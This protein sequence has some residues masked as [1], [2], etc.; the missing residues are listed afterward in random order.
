[1]F[2]EISSCANIKSK[3][4]R[5]SV[6]SAL[7]QIQHYFKN[8]KIPENGIALFSGNQNLTI[9]VPPTPITHFLY[10]CDKLFHT[11]GLMPLYEIH[12]HNGIVLV[13]GSCCYIY[14]VTNIKTTLLYKTSVSLQSRQKKGGQS[15]VRIARLA[16]ERRFLFVKQIAENINKQY[17]T[18]NSV[19]VKSIVIAGP[20]EMK[21]AVVNSELLDYRL[22][23]LVTKITIDTITDDTLAK[24]I[25][26]NLFDKQQVSEDELLAKQIITSIEL[27]ENKYVYGLEEIQR[28]I[29]CHNV[30][31]L[32]TADSYVCQYFDVDI[33]IL[34]SDLLLAY[35]GVILQPYYTMDFEDQD[36]LAAAAEDEDI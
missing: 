34:K 28:Y 1:M 30:H 31:C 27:G 11:E 21:D 33:Q 22:R 10:K 24:I 5:K 32:Y 29:D 6:E 15:A 14:D 19:N 20:A 23:P 17:L 25:A 12:T 18:N 8:N 7:K 26:L 2:D 3:P 16:E 13:S 9:I 35:G 4:T 36:E